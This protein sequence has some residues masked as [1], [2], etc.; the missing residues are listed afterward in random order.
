MALGDLLIVA[1]ERFEVYKVAGVG[2]WRKFVPGLKLPGRG[3]KQG[4][5]E[6]AHRDW[7]L[8]ISLT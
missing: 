5:S 4:A 2:T 6:V 7:Q 8:R 3:R 1:N